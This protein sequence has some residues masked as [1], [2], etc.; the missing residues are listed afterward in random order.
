M[1]KLQLYISGERIDLF[2]DEQVSISLSQQDVKDPAKIFAEFTKTFTIPASKNNNKIFEHYY[3][4]DIINGFDARNKVTSNIELNNIPYKQ[5]FVA[6]NGVE[7]KNNKAYAYKITFYGNTINLTKVFGED[8]L[9]DLGEL[10]TNNLIY[11]ATTVKSKLQGTIGDNIIA[12]LITHTEQLF[13]DTNASVQTFGN[14]NYI[15]GQNHGVLYSELKYAIRVDLIVQAIQ[16]HYAGSGLPAFSDDFF[17]LATSQN[18]QYNNLYMWLHRKKGNV[19]SAQQVVTFA[20]QVGVYELSSYTTIQ[21][22][23]LLSGGGTNFS[24]IPGYEN[25]LNNTLDLFVKTGY[26]T[27]P[28][29]IELWRNGSIYWTSTEAAGSRSFNKN[30]TGGF[31][32]LPVGVYYLNIR[33]A[34]A[35]TFT[36]IMWTFQGNIQQPSAPNGWENIFETNPSPQT[37][38][39]EFN[40]TLDFDFVISAQIPTIKVIDFMNGLFRMFNLTANYDNQPLLVNGNSNPDF[41]KIKIQT[42]DQFYSSNFNT[43]DISKYVNVNKSSVD[44]G[45]PYNEISFSYEGVDTLLAATFSQE[46]STKWGA[47]KYSG[48]TRLTGPNTSYAILAP[49]EHMQFERLYNQ[50]NNAATTIQYGRFVNDNQEPYLGK[51]LLFYPIK[52]TNGTEISFMT[53]T[54]SHD[55]IDD[56]IIPSNSQELDFNTSTSNINFNEESNEYTGAS[57]FSGTLFQ[58]YYSTYITDVFNTQRRI[59]KISAYLPLRIIYKL[60][61]NDVISINNKTYII[62]NANINLITGESSFELL[63]RITQSYSVLS[64]VSYQN[65]ARSVFYNSVIGNASNLSNGDVIYADT[66]LTNALPAG[67]YTQVGS[68]ELTTHCESTFAMSMTLNSS[69]AITAISCAQP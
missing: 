43:W 52:Q 30:V 50:S 46:N 27:I 32:T 55:A 62:N 29:T 10:N 3:N 28:Y 41:G 47:L 36:N 33:T 56:Y 17:N 4:Y 60:Q 63:N 49:F 13:Y 66:A 59:T 7:L 24:I 34:T 69:G 37:S 31:G 16:T 21:S 9:S 19:A 68:A 57:G 15:N 42:L 58:N 54:T 1:Q 39:K 53:T 25:L 26:T 51:P 65:I 38:T 40:A 8:D 44:V 6:L 18:K 11:N 12:P 67:T 14:L 61:M 20:T 64:N 23:V 2:K 22:A 35:M 45:L 48:G 5:G